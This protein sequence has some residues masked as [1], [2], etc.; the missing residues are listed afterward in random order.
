VGA[1]LV[2]QAFKE[3]KLTIYYWREG[4][5]EVDFVEEYKN[6]SSLLKSRPLKLGDLQA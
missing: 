1:H 4:N 5:E 3:K 2:N 6:E